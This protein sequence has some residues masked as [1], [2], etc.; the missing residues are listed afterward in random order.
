MRFWSMN[1]GLLLA[2]LMVWALLAGPAEI[3]ASDQSAAPDAAKPS[4]T[5][6]SV[7]P[8]MRI[9]Y[10]SR[11]NDPAYGEVPSG[12]GVFRPPIFEPFPGAELAIKDTL[13]TARAAG[14]SFKLQ[15]R[16]VPEGEPIDSS[17]LADAAAVIADV[18]EEDF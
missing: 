8:V 17:S 18:P 13:A 5:A 12:D 10:L 4:A 14:I 1:K 3:A 16:V 9:V 6:Q 15:K 11:E 2:A 7:L